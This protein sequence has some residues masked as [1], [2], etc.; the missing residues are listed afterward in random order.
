MSEIKNPKLQLAKEFVEFTGRN[1]FLTGKAG[2]GKT[3]FLHNLK[4][5]SSKRMIVVAPT[6]VAAINAGGVTIHSFFQLP[7][8]PQVPGYNP[9]Q[10]E[11]R[12]RYN[13]FN[14]EKI[15]I[16]K[17][18]DLLVI[19]EISMVRAD[20]LDS[21]DTVLKKYKNGSQPFGGVQLLMIGDMNQLAPVVKDHDW[22]ILRTYY[23]TA[24]FFSSKALQKTSFVSIELMHV[25]RQSDIKFIRL[26]NKVRDDKLDNESINILNT[27]FDPSF[28][29]KDESYITL[30]THNAKAQN[31]NNQ[32]LKT[33]KNKSRSFTAEVKGDFPEYNFP[34]ED[35]L[36]LKEGA[37]VMF[38]KNDPSYAKRF[39]NGKIGKIVSLE[40]DEILVQCEGEEEPISVEPLEWDNVKYT[41]DEKSKEIQESIMGKFIQIP[42]KL[43]WAI[44]IHKSQG[45][46]FEKAIIDSA[47][48]F[49]FG[50]VYVAL[51]RCKSLEG[52]VLSS[53]IEPRSI[54]SDK[55]INSFT[56]D[57]E[58]HQPDSKQLHDSKLAFQQDLINELF[59]FEYI[60]NLIYKNIKFVG[61]NKSSLPKGL[62]Q[63]FNDILNNFNKEILTV[64]GK[65]A[66]Q[67]Q[68]LLYENSNPEENA[69]LQDRI[70]KAS[71]YFSQKLK[72]SVLDAVTN[73][74][75]ETDNTQVKKQQKEIREK[76]MKQSHY[77]N[78]C[79]E[80][81]K[82]GFNLKNY[83]SV[84]AKASLEEL[85]KKAKAK[86]SDY[87]ASDQSKSP[88]Y[89]A[90]KNWRN[91]KADELNWKVFRILQLKS[92]NEIADRMPQSKEEL[93]SIN[94]IGKKKMELF[95]DE[96]LD[97]VSDYVRDHSDQH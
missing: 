54:K 31:I 32:K 53:P 60:R 9:Q 89:L 34:T 76:L 3:T 24:F 6:G 2:T 27:R 46:T 82:M 84:R 69:P 55:V 51:S 59:D 87:N 88:L 38:I 86:K 91:L 15:K 30:T 61:D 68:L 75:S 71:T 17:S 45:L 22:A 37:Q 44:T 56:Q 10:N 97:V 63:D 93:F 70:K 14:K 67:L 36:T 62:Y 96:I 94:G 26:L 42:L 48:A 66:S 28:D 49:A 85:P 43:A 52:M 72:E 79:L 20:M 78:L 21:I 11:E 47:S 4:K 64:A 1:I 39:F 35:K 29:P 5:E 13:R 8:G 74:A 18:L 80:S 23:D 7:F 92:I 57:V 58:S 90:L 16:I 33:L 77:K 41:L 19:D 95:G 12:I 65:F 73:L 40:D 81:C 83:L 25:Y 50:Q